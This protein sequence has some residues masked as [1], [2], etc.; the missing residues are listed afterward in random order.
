MKVLRTIAMAVLLLF[1]SAPAALA[2][3]SIEDARWLAGRWVGEGLG[4]EMEESWSAPAQ[5]RMV[6]YFRLV[7]EE[8]VAFYELMLLEET[9]AGLEMRVKH[10]TPDFV[11]WEEKDAW[12]RFAPLRAAP[13]VLEFQGLSL[14]LEG[15][16]MIGV[17]RLRYGE[18]DVRD[19]VLRYRRAPL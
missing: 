1:C 16:T 4:G 5:G 12:V 10:F 15:E 17:I 14:R 6:G 2:Q 13:G 18:S 3:A 7:R 9:E 8:R 11:G 19:E